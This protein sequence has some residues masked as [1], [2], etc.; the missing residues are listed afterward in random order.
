MKKD[1]LIR[2]REGGSLSYIEKIKLVTTLSMPSIVAQLSSILMQYIDASMVGRLGADAAASIGLVST[3]TWLFGGLA[4]SA[5][6][7]FSIQVAQFVGAKEYEKARQVLKNSYLVVLALALLLALVGLAISG[8]LPVWLHGAPNIRSDATWYFRIYSVSLVGMALNRLAGSML[9]CSGNM[10]IPGILNSLMCVLDVLFNLAFIYGLKLGVKGAAL[11]TALAVV[12]TM[13]LMLYFLWKRTPLLA[14]RKEEAYVFHRDYVSRALRLA[15]PVAFEHLVVCGA[16]VVT[17]RIVAPLGVI[18]IAANSFAVTAES[19]C[20][21]PGY[22]IADAATTLTGQSVGAGRKELA[23]SFGKMTVSFGMI[24]MA[25]MGVFMYVAAPFLMKLLSTDSAVCE[26]GVKVL[27]I[28]AFAE[29][30]YGASIVCTGV[31][32][33]AGDTL[34]PGILNFISLW[35][36]RLPL[37]YWLGAQY[38]LV[39]IWLAMC[40]ELCFRGTV[41]LIRLVRRRWILPNER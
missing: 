3:T 33:G 26:L 39:G 31:L 10:K 12:V 21:M 38:G 9:Q 17:T 18:A 35:L 25:V 41:F 7:G 5:A 13:A 19:L 14:R 1:L 36:V 40:L 15:W 6:V 23:W 34:V 32:R 22:G 11:G 2:V 24:L 8:S 27:R 29:P 20:Y 4:T 37:S 28:E 30:L 16:M